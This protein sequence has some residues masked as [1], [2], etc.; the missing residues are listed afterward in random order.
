MEKGI[1]EFDIP[2]T[3][4]FRV[5]RIHLDQE[6]TQ[7]VNFIADLFNLTFYG[8]ENFDVPYTKADFQKLVL[9]EGLIFPKLT[10]N[11]PYKARGRVLIFEFEGQ[12]L[13]KGEFG[14]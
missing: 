11:G 12:G 5:D 6:N 9:E 10:M 8:V 13:A 3:T 7:N 14:K 2:P 1:P 4:E